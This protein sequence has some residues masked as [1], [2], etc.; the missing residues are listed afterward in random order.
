MLAWLVVQ[1]EVVSLTHSAVHQSN[2]FSY[3]ASYSRKPP[4]HD[5]GTDAGDWF[6]LFLG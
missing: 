2:I 1:W 6:Y 5:K 4:F 3:D